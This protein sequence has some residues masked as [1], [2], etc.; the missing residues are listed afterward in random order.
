M[1]KVKGILY[2]IPSWLSPGTQAMMP[3]VVVEVTRRIRHYF[4]EN[5]RSA[6]RFLKAMD[7]TID[8]D[9]CTF[10]LVNVTE[11]PD[12]AMLQQWL[13][14]DKEIGVISEAGYPCIADPGELL[15][16]EAHRLGAKVVPLSGPNAMIMALAASGLNG[17]RFCFSGY[18]PIRSSDRI[19]SLKVL[20]K[21]MLQTQETQI[22]MET[23]YR[24][25]ALVQDMLAHLQP[26]TQLCIAADITAPSEYIETHR[27]QEWAG[28]VPDLHKRPAVFLLG[29]S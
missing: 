3:P 18:L 16:R 28:K 10:S 1:S 12:R 9:A 22:F 2:L 6:R 11:K 29:T 27:I 20:E 14:E 26:S 17:E 19:R 5:E 4:V 25:N 23:P 7:R 13:M 21:K 24:N 15:V 8:I